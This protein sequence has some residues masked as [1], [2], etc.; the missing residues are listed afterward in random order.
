[1]S[2][3]PVDLPPAADFSAVTATYDKASYTTGDPVKSSITG[4]AKVASSI[5]VTLNLADDDGATGTLSTTVPL[6]KLEGV[7]IV[8][9]SD[10]SGR[11]W[12]VAA[13]GLSASSTA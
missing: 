10:P 6:T 5:A 13:D 2:V 7:K 1:M 8:S 12:T 3:D 9:V 11:T 4:K